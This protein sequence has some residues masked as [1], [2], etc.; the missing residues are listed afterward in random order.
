LDKAIQLRPN[1]VRPY[2]SPHSLE[3]EH[4]TSRW[5]EDFYFQSLPRTRYRRNTG[6]ESRK[7]PGGG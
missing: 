2:K 1:A 7:L 4:A 3:I 5:F 6:R